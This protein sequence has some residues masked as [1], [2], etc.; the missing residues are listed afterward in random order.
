MNEEAKPYVTAL[1]EVKV[2]RAEEQLQCNSL[3]IVCQIC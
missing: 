3:F 1:A 2:G